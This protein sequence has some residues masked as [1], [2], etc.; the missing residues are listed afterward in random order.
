MAVITQT[1]TQI[2]DKAN[3]YVLANSTLTNVRSSG[4]LNAVNGGTAAVLTAF[5]RDLQIGV[6]TNAIQGAFDAFGFNSLPAQSATVTLSVNVTQ[7]TT[8]PQG[9]TASTV[10]TPST[11]AVVFQTLA[12]TAV[13]AAGTVSVTMSAV[14]PGTSGNVPAASITNI[15]TPVAGVVSV[16]NPASASGGVNAESLSA[17]LARFQVYLQSLADATNVALAY[18]AS[19]VSGVVLSNAVGNPYL[20]GIQQNTT[21]YN[22]YTTSLNSP[23]GVPFAPFVATPTAGD[24]FYI[25]ST[26]LFS[27]LYLD[28]STA[29]SGLTATWEYWDGSAW[30]A[31]SP[32]IDQTS[33]GQT[34]GSVAWAIPSDWASTTVGGL[35]AFYIRLNLTSAAYTTMPTWYSGFANDPPPGFVYVY[36]TT[37]P[38]ATN[39][40]TSV[41]A[42]LEAVR[43]SGDTVIVQNATLVVETLSLTVIPTQTGAAQDL[44]S[45]V[46]TAITNLFSALQIGESLPLSA[47]I[48]AVQGIGNGTYITQVNISSPTTDMIAAP[49]QWLTVGTVSVALGAVA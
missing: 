22:V 32:T 1:K 40:L 27:G 30:G 28:V 39:V 18:A 23:K 2:Q 36:V 5:Y 4:R 10:G 43:A 11:P 13:A 35:S 24:S 9:F 44:V 15:I 46:Q 29:G 7:A 41:Q 16:T 20:T 25:G 47:V 34:S 19:Q 42:A 17:Q 37:N 38:S 3:A 33:N 26:G 6:Y 21:I 49:S 31:L 45:L 12:A 14:I 8:I 48:S